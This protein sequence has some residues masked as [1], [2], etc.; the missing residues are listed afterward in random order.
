MVFPDGLSRRGWAHF[1]G[2]QQRSQGQ[3][4]RF[5]NHPRRGHG[6]RDGMRLSQ[7]GTMCRVR[8]EEE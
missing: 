6:L 7:P 2:A 8:G 4:Y 1:S 5:G 3:R